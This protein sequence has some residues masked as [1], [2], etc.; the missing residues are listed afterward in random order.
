MSVF[1]AAFLADIHYFSPTLGTKGRAYE[2]RSGSDQKCLAESGAVVDEAFRLLAEGDA[3][4]VCIAGDLTNDGERVSHDEML[5]RMKALNEK[6]PVYAI[7]STHDWCSDGRARRYRGG[8]TFWDVE[9]YGPEDLPELYRCFG[10]KEEI[11][12]FRTSRGFDSRVFRLSD[13]L[14][15]IAVNDDCDGEGGRSGYSPAH[16]AWMT[17]QIK[18]ARAEGAYV[19]AMEHHLLLHA[20]GE[21]EE[22]LGL[23]LHGLVAVVDGGREFDEDAQAVALGAV[24]GL[25]EAVVDVHAI[26]IDAEALAPAVEETD[27]GNAD[28]VVVA[29]IDHEEGGGGADARYDGVEPQ[30]VFGKGQAVARPGVEFLLVHARAEQQ[31]GGENG[32]QYG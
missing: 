5:A 15:L 12:S 23:Q 11:A 4:C 2:L 6:K 24:D 31:R 32:Q 18:K 19:I 29:V 13:E 25:R 17:E 14:R 1:K 20:V 28:A 27:V 26:D 16:L 9:T 21:G 22:E 10:E 3:D 8:E 7:T 30:G